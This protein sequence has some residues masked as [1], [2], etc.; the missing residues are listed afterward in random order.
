[1]K[2]QLKNYRQSPR[3]VRLV[4]NLI[5]GKPV[6]R[7]L[8]LLDTTP[9]RATGTLKKMLESAIANAQQQQT[10]MENL[11]IKEIRVDK[12]ITLHRSMPRAHGRAFRIDKH[13]SNV[14]V[15]LEEKEQKPK[16]KTKKTNKKSE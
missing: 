3:K 15:V 11:F 7:A 14:I 13:T 10:G 9:K 8:L 16:T 12:G 6:Q 1:M 2:A 5:K 4:A